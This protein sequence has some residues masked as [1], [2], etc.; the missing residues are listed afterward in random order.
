MFNALDFDD[1]PSQ[2]QDFGK[3]AQHK[4]TQKKGQ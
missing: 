4:D 3:D 2:H 1:T